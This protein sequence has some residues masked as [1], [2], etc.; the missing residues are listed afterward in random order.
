MVVDAEEFYGE[1]VEHLVQTG[2]KARGD[3]FNIEIEGCP[4]LSALTVGCSPELP[5]RTP[6]EDVAG[7]QGVTINEP[8]PL[9]TGGMFPLTYHDGFSGKAF[10]EYMEWMKDAVDFTKRK[11]VRVW[12]RHELGDSALDVTYLYCWPEHEPGEFDAENKTAPNKFSVNLHFANRRWTKD[13][14]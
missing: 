12:G 1:E 7:R 6:V 14:K 9:K 3:N 2:N 10:E 5:G 13:L 8:G 11:K 4:N